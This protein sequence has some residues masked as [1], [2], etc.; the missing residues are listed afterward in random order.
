MPEIEKKEPFIDKVNRILLSQNNS[1]ERSVTIEKVD[2]SEKDERWSWVQ[3][4]GQ[5][6]WLWHTIDHISGKVCLPIKDI[7]PILPPITYCV[8]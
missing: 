2:E 4:K 7:T 1:S 6:R 3:N 5:Q 8:K